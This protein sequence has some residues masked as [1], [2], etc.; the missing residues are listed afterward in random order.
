MPP[1]PLASA[2]I[3][4]PVLA[5]CAL[6]TSFD[7]YDTVAPATQHY[8]VRGNVSGLEGSARVTLLLNGANAMTVGNGAFAFP[9]G[10]A[11]PR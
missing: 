7:A 1:R 4:L 6:T 10:R 2:L 9:G 11:G 5:S 8:G 3:L